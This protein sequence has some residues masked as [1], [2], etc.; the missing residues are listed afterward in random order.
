MAM[1]RP[2][3]R[4]VLW[5]ALGLLTPAAGLA[6]REV[7]EVV[8]VAV[9]HGDPRLPRG[10]DGTQ[11]ID[12]LEG[13]RADGYTQFVAGTGT[14]PDA[15]LAMLETL[16]PEQRRAALR[17][18]IR[19]GIPEDPAR[20]LAV[21]DDATAAIE[22]GHGEHPALL[23]LAAAHPRLTQHTD[24]LFAL[25]RRALAG[26]PD[27]TRY[28]DIRRDLLAVL[29]NAQSALSQA[30]AARVSEVVPGQVLVVAAL[31]ARDVQ[32]GLTNRGLPC[33]V[34]ATSRAQ[35]LLEDSH[36][37]WAQLRSAL[38][39]PGGA[40]L[41]P[42]IEAV[43]PV[44]VELAT[45]KHR[46]AVLRA[47][48]AQTGPAPLP[49]PTADPV[50]LHLELAAKLLTPE[51][52]ALLQQVELT[53]RPQSAFAV[54]YDSFHDILRMSPWIP[55]LPLPLSAAL[56][57]H[58]LVHVRDTRAAAAALGITPRDWALMLDTSPYGVTYGLHCTTE[59]AA[60]AVEVAAL[61]PLGVDLDT[62]QGP[63]ERS[64]KTMLAELSKHEPTS[65]AWRSLIDSIVGVGL[66]SP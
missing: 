57:V 62:A 43:G 36:L 42:W 44:V 46:G 11:A 12:L 41:D 55:E 29:H 26:G 63:K 13:L 21:L 35:A 4:S 52:R 34:V 28:R 16:P 22:G 27:G 45:W 32:L 59:S 65:A 31:A 39:S 47:I 56:L 17:E 40:G 3:R 10:V 9:A 24:P 64:L 20:L 61:G 53:S 23:E 7:L 50:R 49:L 2:D 6:R 60:Y 48:V 30:T 25:R 5:G 19:Q 66:P 37:W 33:R 1:L 18:G 14:P 38:P 51:Q 15:G 8:I 58:E 54:S